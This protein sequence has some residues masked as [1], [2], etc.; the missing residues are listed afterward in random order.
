MIT[1]TIEDGLNRQIELEASSSQLYLS[2]AS[3]A[4][5]EGYEGI[6]DFLFQQSNEER[7]HMLKIFHYLNDRGGH[8][9]VKALDEPTGDFESIISVF[10]QVYEHEMMVSQEINNLTA[11]CLEEK[12][13]MT[14]N[15]LQWYVTEQIEEESLAR[16][17][18]DKLK[19]IGNDKGGHYMFDRDIRAM[20]PPADAH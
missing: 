14:Y 9:R 1:K 11:G 3:W 7:I 20:R 12:D 2:M 6:S 13:Y 15:F 10:E 5:V 16:K 17:I 4:E 19:L 18:L 8:A